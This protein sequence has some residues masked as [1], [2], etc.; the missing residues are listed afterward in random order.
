M[1]EKL[2]DK[3]DMNSAKQN[4]HETIDILLHM[5]KKLKFMNSE[6]IN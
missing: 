6:C 4:I 1:F 5:D 2:S 3:I